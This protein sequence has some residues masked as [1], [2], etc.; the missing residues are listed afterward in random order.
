ML[1]SK[2][3]RRI[4]VITRPIS[5]HVI[6]S[7]HAI[8]NVSYYEG[9]F[10]GERISDDQIEQMSDEQRRRISYIINDEEQRLRYKFEN[11][12]LG[13][14]EFSRTHYLKL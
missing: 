11:S 2:M 12:F 1:K 9:W 7:T 10:G 6:E 4:R 3:K 5:H 14:K 13:G 8:V